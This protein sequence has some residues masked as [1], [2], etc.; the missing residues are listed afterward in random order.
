M[1]D[2]RF[3]SHHDAEQFYKD[4]LTKRMSS[5]QELYDDLE[6]PIKA[7][8][9]AIYIHIPFCDKICS[10]CNMNRTLSTNPKND[11]VDKL[12]MQIKEL[13]NKNAF[14]TSLIEAVYFGG[15]TPTTLLPKHFK[16]IIIALSSSFKLSSNVE[17]TCETTL[18]NL[19]TDHIKIFNEIG[20]NRISIG[21]QTFQDEGRHFFN[22]SFN[23]KEVI[24]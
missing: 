6:H 19:S 3:K 10:F 17:I 12:L 4:L 9:N 11:Y 24:K 16:E 8:R 5:K 22:R 14:N 18:H 1:F 13:G 23:K 15:G 2:R 21:I 7:S 20:I